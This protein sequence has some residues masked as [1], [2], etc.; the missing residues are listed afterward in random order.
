M[1]TKTMLVA[2]TCLCAFNSLQGNAQVVGGNTLAATVVE[3]HRITL[4]DSI[5][6]HISGAKIA[7]KSLQIKKFGAKN[8][9][10]TD[11]R[12]AFA[13][14]IKKASAMKGAKIVVPA[15]TYYIKGPIVLASNICLE[16]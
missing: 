8:D 15:G 10:K 11:C 14:A 4:R 7:E 16:L 5:L 13:K 6:N 3:Q 1:D 9:G 12:A 2:M